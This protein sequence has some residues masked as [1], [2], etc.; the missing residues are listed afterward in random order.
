MP[1]STVEL[2]SIDLLGVNA[3]LLKIDGNLIYLRCLGCGYVYTVPKESVGN[4][5]W[6]A[7][8]ESTPNLSE[9]V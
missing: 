7:C 8:P 9:E 5:N 6:Y 1:D 4:I 2:D 3:L